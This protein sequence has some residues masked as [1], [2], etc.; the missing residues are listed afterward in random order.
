MGI[1]N[2][3]YGMFDDAINAL[4]ELTIGGEK[5]E[6]EDDE[7]AIED[8]DETT[9]DEN[10]EE[11]ETPEGEAE[12]Q[13]AAEDA[14]D[15][16]PA[17]ATAATDTPENANDADDGIDDDFSLPD[18]DLGDDTGTE[19]QTEDTSTPDDPT[20]DD[21]GGTTDDT[22]TDD[23][24]DDFSMPEDGDTGTEDET[25]TTGE[26]GTGGVEETGESSIGDSGNDQDEL[27]Q[28]EDKL[29][30]TLTDD[31]KKIRIL[32]LK[33]LFKNIYEQADST[34]NSINDIPK[35]D[36]NIDIIRRL[37][38]VLNN[39]K[40]Y[41]T[42]YMNFEFDNHTYLDNNQIYIKYINIFRTIQKTI[43]ELAKTEK[44]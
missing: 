12:P 7:F 2:S 13:A 16:E 15:I 18:D 32:Q 30:D 4:N 39:V 34:L 8:D 3:Y 41:I 5:I 14:D 22:T 40:D 42:D 11:P 36:E 28:E 31:Q 21:E 44:G 24:P 37:I 38:V 9:D 10:A 26:E 23:V 25:G 33:I 1:F 27:K 35:S 29:Y 43:E 17:E 19:E 6:D 20:T